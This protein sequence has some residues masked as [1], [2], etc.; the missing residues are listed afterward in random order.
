MRDTIL[1]ASSIDGL[2]LEFNLDGHFNLSVGARDWY[3]PAVTLA[4][5][6][7]VKK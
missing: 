4:N 1:T 3:S 2:V 5:A 6:P 7:T